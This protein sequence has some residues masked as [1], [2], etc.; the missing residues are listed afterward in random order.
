MASELY[1]ET[2]KGLT[3]GANANKVIVPAGQTLDASAGSV[4]LPAGA[5]GKVLQVLQTTTTVYQGVQSTSFTTLAN[6]NPSI[7]PSSTSSKILVL[8][9]LSADAFQNGNGAYSTEMKLLRGATQISFKRADHYGGTASNSF[10][11]FHAQNDFIYLDSPSSTSAQTYTVQVRITNTANT[12]TYR[13]QDNSAGESTIT[14]M[15]I[16][17]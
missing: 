17:G 2:L 15:E 16:A 5:G 1:V 3:S 4:V 8:V 12:A 14:L 11:S 7:T 13:F 9:S 10:Y 6:L